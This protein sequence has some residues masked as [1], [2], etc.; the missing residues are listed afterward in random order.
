MQLLQDFRHICNIISRASRLLK[1]FF[2]RSI[3]GIICWESQAV[4]STGCATSHRLK[5]GPLP[6]NDFG[7]IAQHVRE[8]KG[9]NGEKDSRLS[10]KESVTHL[11]EVLTFPLRKYN[12][13]HTR[14]SRGRPRTRMI[15]QIRKD[16]EMRGENW[17]E[18]QEDRERENRNGWRF[19][20][21]SQ[22]LTLETT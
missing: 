5:W 1:C 14:D 12:A 11:R 10:R 13:Q 16:I 18:I 22:T 2:L 8:K 3:W 4:I 19:L 20:C 9:R 7:S 17:E 15:D 6:P 21:N